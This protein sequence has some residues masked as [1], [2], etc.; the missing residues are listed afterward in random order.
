[1]SWLDLR[2]LV[3]AALLPLGACV[4]VTP[5]RLDASMTIT[6]ERGPCFGACPDYT[7]T[8]APDGAV[9]YEGRRFVRVT[10]AQTGRADP[11]ALAALREHILR[12][13]FFSLRPS[14][15]AHVTDLPTYRVTVTEGTR[16]HS[17]EDYG[18]TMD[19]GM[20]PVVREIE[21]EIDSVA[22]TAQ[23]VRIER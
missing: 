6:L 15:R 7:V 5:E 23:W 19:T 10:G 2:A 12:A 16:V 20:P 4:N 8:I 21:D 14:Y 9:S 18:G 11:A 3:I 22:G 1:M 17:V 13:N